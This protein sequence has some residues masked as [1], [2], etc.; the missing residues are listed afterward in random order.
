M[1][2]KYSTGNFE[3]TIRVGESSRSTNRTRRALIRTVSKLEPILRIGSQVRCLY[4]DGEIDIVARE[5]LTGVDR[6]T[7][8]RGRG[9]DRVANADGNR[10]VRPWDVGFVQSDWGRDGA[11]P[12]KDRGVEGVTLTSE[13][14]PRKGQG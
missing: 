5:C 4:F 7:K 11:R 14:E 9:E 10:L 13:F 12:K 3:L 8:K 6:A 2:I 1:G